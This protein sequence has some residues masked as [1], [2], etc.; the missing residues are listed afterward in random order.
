MTR[1]TYHKIAEGLGEPIAPKEQK[2]TKVFVPAE[3]DIRAIRAKLNLSQEDFAST[4]R[5]HCA[6]NATMGAGS[7]A[8]CGR[9]ARV[10]D[11]HR[12]QPEA[13]IGNVARGGWA[14]RQACL[15]F[16]PIPIL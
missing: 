16:M 14:G 1:R 13:C 4:L 2:P 11:D 8:T 6:S 3:I 7:I 9:G 12:S 10:S 15:Q 5:L